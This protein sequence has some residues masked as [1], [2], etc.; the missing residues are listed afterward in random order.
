MKLPNIPT[1]TMGGHVFWTT[2]HHKNGWKLQQNK[3]TQTYRIL[4]PAETR[5]SWGPNYWEM[6]NSF[7]MFSE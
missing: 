6:K 2:M 5:R 7:D 4:D 1:P 3:I